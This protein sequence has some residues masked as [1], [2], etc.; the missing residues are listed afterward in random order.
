M[1]KDNKFNGMNTALFLSFYEKAKQE[2]ARAVKARA[3]QARA[4]QSPLL[5]DAI[6]SSIETQYDIYT[7]RVKNI[8]DQKQP[9]AIRNRIGILKPPKLVLPPN[10]GKNVVTFIDGTEKPLSDILLEA[11]KPFK[12]LFLQTPPLLTRLIAN[13]DTINKVP[14]TPQQYIQNFEKK[15][16]KFANYN[17]FFKKSPK[18]ANDLILQILQNNSGLNTT[19]SANAI[20]LELSKKF[21]IVPPRPP[22]PPVPPRPARFARPPGPPPPPPPLPPSLLP[23]AA[24]APP[25]VPAPAPAAAAAQRPPLHHS[26]NINADI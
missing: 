12:I 5:F 6:K 23:T 24:A 11:P 9:D 1:T 19:A 8:E 10:L 3:V 17:N 21:N 22:R 2:Q 26:L 7:K 20:L 25:P 4:V 13:L 18:V 14:T 16:K 15:L